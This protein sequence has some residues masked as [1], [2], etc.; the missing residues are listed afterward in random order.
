MAFPTSSQSQYLLNQVALSNATRRLW[1]DNNQWTRALIQSI[2]Y[3]QGNQEELLDRIRENAEDFATLFGQFYGEE[4]GRQIGKYIS[5]DLDGMLRL[6]EAY[7][8]DDTQAIRS[9]REYLYSNASELSRYLA[10]I[11]RY[12]DMATL[13]VMLHERLN[14]AE[15]EI[16]LLRDQ[17]FAQSID[18]HD[19]LMTQG[20]KLADELSYGILKQFQV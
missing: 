18:Q 2:L 10:R 6:I 16:I 1:V 15:Y 7:K 5:N 13:E 14:L 17:E 19:E 4:S 3:D 8:A 11:N 20:Y 9:A 12:L